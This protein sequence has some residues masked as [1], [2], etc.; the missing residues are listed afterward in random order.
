MVQ[1]CRPTSYQPQHQPLVRK[2]RPLGSLAWSPG[3]TGGAAQ[4]LGLSSCLCRPR[5]TALGA[6][7]DLVPGPHHM[8]ITQFL[9]HG[10]Y[11]G[12]YSHGCVCPWT[13]FSGRPCAPA[14]S[15]SGYPLVPRLSPPFQAGTWGPAPWGENSSVPAAC[16]SDPAHRGL[17][18]LCC[19]FLSST[20]PDPYLAHHCLTHLDIVSLSQGE[21]PTCL[22]TWPLL[23]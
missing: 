17:I 11:P 19:F 15:W 22:S 12:P 5:G 1:S 18:F 16:A 23:T 7:C 3:P 6:P 13:L 8:T 20:W 14:S 21:S 9:S 4:S 2:V 10:P